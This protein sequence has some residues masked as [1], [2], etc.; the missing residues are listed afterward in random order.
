LYVFVRDFFATVEG[1]LVR[2]RKD[3]TPD[4]PFDSFSVSGDART[5]PRRITLKI[6]NR[7][8]IF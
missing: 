2:G 8:D 6:K 1:R 3:L 4:N 5:L 7:N